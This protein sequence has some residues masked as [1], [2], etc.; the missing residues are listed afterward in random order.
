MQIFKIKNENR[1]LL[2]VAQCVK[3]KLQNKQFLKKGDLKNFV[4]IKSFTM[5]QNGE[6]CNNLTQTA[7]LNGS[8]YHRCETDGLRVSSGP[9]YNY[10]W[11]WENFREKYF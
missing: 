6:K 2:K 5:R 7:L 4:I 3:R 11:P 10:I 1:C 8:L 9:A